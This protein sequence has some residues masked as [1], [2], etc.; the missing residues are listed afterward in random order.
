MSN[1]TDKLYSIFIDPRNKKICGFDGYYTLYINDIKKFEKHIIPKYFNHNNF[2][3]FERQLNY[4]GFNRNSESEKKYTIIQKDKLFS[5]DGA[6]KI[7][8][9][10]KNL[11]NSNLDSDIFKAFDNEKFMINEIIERNILSNFYY[12]C[13][14][15]PPQY[16]DEIIMI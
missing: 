4:Y 2:K 8:R 13:P 6:C 3:S 9:N 10:N 15:T 5:K 7:I 16:Y 11:E 14:K 1:F 12:F